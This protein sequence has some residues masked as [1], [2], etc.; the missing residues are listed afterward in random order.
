[1]T[2]MDGQHRAW[3]VASLTPNLRTMLSQ[4][5][6]SL[7]A[8]AL[9]MEMRLY[10]TPIQDLGLGVQQIHAQ[11]QNFCLEMQNLK[12]AKTPQLEVHEEVWC[13]K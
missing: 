4:Q 11:L 12:Q 5:K 2:L 8:E 13:I 10:E 7:Q 1:M 3:F 6:L 9:E